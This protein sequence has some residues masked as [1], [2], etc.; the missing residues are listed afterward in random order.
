MN[1][2]QV[3]QNSEF[4]ELGVLEVNGKPYFPATACAKA[5]GYQ[6]P[7]DTVRQHCRYST[8]YRVPHPQN[9]SKEIEMNFIPEGDL[10]RLI[11]HSKLPA[12]ER[13]EK[14]VFDE[15]LPSIRRTGGYG[16]VDVTA[17]IMQ[18]ATAVCAEMVKQLT[19]LFQ[20]MTRAPAPPTSAEYMVL[21]DI[22]VKR[23]RL[24]KRSASIIDRLC[25]ELRRE[26][27]EMLCDGRHTYSEICIRLRQEGISISAAS[28]CRYA[29]RTGCYATYEAESE[30]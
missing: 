10:Y 5:L 18:T 7:Q 14:W 13:F 19:P 2:M 23:P 4:G 30:D 27:E 15:V 26:V 21:D 29:K 3:F 9:P 1:E 28:V 17:I 22:P 16:Q 12:A 6:R 25:P 24:R 8:K 20:G 11:T